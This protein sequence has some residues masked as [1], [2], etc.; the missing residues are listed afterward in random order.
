MNPRASSPHTPDAA[1]G[2]SAGQ[3]RNDRIPRRVWIGLVAIA[4]YVLVAVAGSNAVSAALPVGD[5]LIQFT[6]NELISLPILILAGLYFVRRSGWG[7]D[8]W[9]ERPTLTMT[10]RRWWLVSIPVLFLLMQLL[11][12]PEVPWA[13]TP[14]TSLG[15]VVM[16]VFVVALGEELFFRGILLTSIRARHGELVTMLTTSLLFGLAHIFGSLEEGVPVA[17]IALQ[18][19]IISMTGTLFY[20]ARR[21]TGTLWAPI[22]LHFLDDYMGITSAGVSSAAQALTTDSSGSSD[23][24]GGLQV[25]LIILSLCAI[26]SAAREDARTRRHAREANSPASTHIPHKA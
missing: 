9:R 18:V 16:A 8:V 17:V 22:L 1:A 11:R 24:V 13:T 20:W 2:M 4:V 25:I 21:V 7:R 26:I 15:L 14:V 23:L 12:I 19:M 3:P 10:P 6:L 5:P